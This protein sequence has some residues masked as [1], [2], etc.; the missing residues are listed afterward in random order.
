M[1]PPKGV[2]III[3]RISVN[4]GGDMWTQIEGL[5]QDYTTLHPEEMRLFLEANKY[6]R[7]IQRNAFGSTRSNS[8]RWG[9]NIP[10][11][12]STLIMKFFPILWDGT[13][14]KENYRKFMRKFPGF[15]VCEKI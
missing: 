4:A 5:I 2:K 13:K 8:F 14:G 7:S 15:R 11:G 3:P 6:A 9:I 10:P 1:A 12:L